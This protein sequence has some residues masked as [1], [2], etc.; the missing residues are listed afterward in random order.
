MSDFLFYAV[1]FALLLGVLI[2][3]HELGHYALARLVG[4]KVLRFSIGFGRPLFLWRA[5]KD[6]TEWAVGVF[7]LGGY[8]RMLGEESEDEVPASE[9]HRCFD[10]QD[11]WKRMLI[12]AAGPLAN[13]V[14]AVVLHWGLFMSGTEELRPV[15]GQPAAESAAAAAGIR[16]GERVLKAGGEPVDTWGDLRWILLRRMMEQDSMALEL[17]DGRGEINIRHLALAEARNP[18][19]GQDPIGLLG[20]R[21]FRPVV[22]AIVGRV[23]SGGA[24]AAAGLSPGDVLLDIGGKPVESWYDV[25]RTVQ[26]SP[27]VP[28]RFRYRRDGKT[29]SVDVTPTRTGSNGREIGRIGVMV[30]DSALD[31]SDLSIVMR[32]APGPAFGKALEETWDKSLF[33]LR[34][35]GR[36]LTGAL[37]WRNISGPVTIADY[38]GQSARLGAEHYLRFMALVS[39]SL[40]VLNLLPIPV[41]DGG[42]LLYDVAEIARGRPLSERWLMIGQKIGLALIVILM[43]FALYNDF[44]RL[45]S[46]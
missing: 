6:G 5:G 10:R 44:T 29:A 18:E 36:M 34:M 46:G 37:S 1:A 26:D 7:P 45:V 14:L 22:P 39:I 4:V 16:N 11:V 24:A 43:V 8:V 23:D 20:L 9:R 15:L 33:T 32:H 13:L 31:R 41:L 21:L 42:H 25:V 35:M 3:V 27:D 12:V 40:A 19:P 17:I 30:A 28:L 2:V 38:A